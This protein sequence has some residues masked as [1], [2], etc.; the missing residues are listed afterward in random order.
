MPGSLLIVGR[1][2][3]EHPE[4]DLVFGNA[5]LVGEEGEP[6]GNYEEVGPVAQVAEHMKALNHVRQGHYDHLLNDHA[7]WIPQQT[8]F[9]RTTAMR[10]VGFLDQDLHFA[11]DYEFCLRLGQNGTVHYLNEFLG[12]YRVHHD[13]KS[14]RAYLHWRDILAVNRR[15]H[16]RLGSRL[17]R[18]FLRAVRHALLRRVNVAGTWRKGEAR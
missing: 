12:A 11:M 15:Y 5:V 7:G 4:V 8:A 16:G 10:R 13:A 9:W 3:A 6:L 17:H 2:F 1:Y 14:T 18:R